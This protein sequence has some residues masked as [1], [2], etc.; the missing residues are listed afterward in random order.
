MEEINMKAK[1]AWEH[2][3]QFI[4][5]LYSFRKQAPCRILRLATFRSKILKQTYLVFWLWSLDHLQSKHIPS[6]PCLQK[7]SVHYLVTRQY[8]QF[9]HGVHRRHYV[10]IWKLTGI[11]RHFISSSYCRKSLAFNVQHHRNE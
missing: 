5:L 8:K 2:T 3:Q 9:L 10:P 7:Q 1:L 11:Q 4:C 6:Y